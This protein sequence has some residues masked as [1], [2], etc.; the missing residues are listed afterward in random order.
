[1]TYFFRILLP[2]SSLILGLVLFHLDDTEARKMLA[3]AQGG[4]VEGIPLETAQ[5]RYVHCALNA[6]AWTLLRE[7]HGQLLWSP[8][9]YWTVATCG[10]FLGFFHCGF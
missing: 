4:A 2:L 7:E 6:P 5:A 3:A 8:S 1:M 9:T 10:I